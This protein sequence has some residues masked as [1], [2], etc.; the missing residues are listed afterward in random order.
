MPPGTIVSICTPEVYDSAK[1]DVL[2][3]LEPEIPIIIEKEYD[4]LMGGQG[5]KRQ[6]TFKMLMEE[7]GM[8]KGESWF[9]MISA[10]VLK[11]DLVKCMDENR[12]F[13]GRCECGNVVTT[14]RSKDDKGKR[15]CLAC[16]K[17]LEVRL[18]S[19]V[20]GGLG[21]ETGGFCNGTAFEEGHGVLMSDLAQRCLLGDMHEELLAGA[22]VLRRGFRSGVEAIEEKLLHERRTF[23]F[24]W[25][26]AWK[27][28]RLI[29]VDVL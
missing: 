5:E 6:M 19:A 14:N 12:L 8:R 16:N 24:C 21:D 22:A 23:V 27:G 15:D 3:E 18:C 11:V 10:V 29:V 7:I 13:V 17:E 26:G 1:F 2:T 28:G 4:E 25:A 20:I 9:A